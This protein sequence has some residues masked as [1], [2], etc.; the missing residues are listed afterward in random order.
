MNPVRILVESMADE[1]AINAQMMNARD[2][3]H[4]LDPGRF[5]ISTFVVGTPD[6]RISKRP[7]TRLIR[8]PLRRQTPRILAEF[9]FGGHDLLFYVKA[10]PASRW[11]M[12]LR[13]I[14]HD[15]RV[16]VGTVE[17]QSNW[18][19]E[20]TI[21][22]QN[23]ALIE[24]TVLRCD[25]LFSNSKSVK[26]SLEAEY[27][28]P[29][30]TVPTGVDT[31]FFSPDWERPNNPRPRVLFVGS[32]RPFKGPQTV[33]EAAERFPQADFVIVGDGIM[34]A[35]IRTAARRQPNV[36][37]AG[38]LSRTSVRNE[39]RQADIFLFPSRWEGS[40]KVILEAA[41]CGLPVIVRKH[42]DPETV[43]DGQTG[44]MV[45]EDDELFSRL[46]QLILSPTVRQTMGRAGRTHSENFDWGRITC[47]W[48]QIFWRLAGNRRGCVT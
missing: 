6:P 37:F 1:D 19:D 13:S 15:R 23:I 24:Q 38:V 35:E 48:E 36:S 16:T 28:L 21:A 32:L 29:S 45:G 20:S 22:P 18:R 39:Y 41:A 33:I 31:K 42:Y 25:Y 17:S 8:L 4:R 46:H 26:R 9:L 34:A 12:K 47:Q 27:G 7:N 43:V 5:H 10:S 2:I 44:Y 14:W 11:Y 3:I 30:E 40:P